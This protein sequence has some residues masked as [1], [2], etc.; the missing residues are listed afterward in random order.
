MEN[1]TISKISNDP[2]ASFSPFAPSSL[3]YQFCQAHGLILIKSQFGLVAVLPVGMA[4]VSSVVLNKKIIPSREN[5]F[6]KVKK[7]DELSHFLFGGSDIVSCSKR[8][9]RVNI[10][11][12]ENETCK[13]I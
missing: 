6:P 8:I 5:P 3:G 1:E 10:A 7:G 13:M 11:R 2:I 9:A 4:Q 12:E